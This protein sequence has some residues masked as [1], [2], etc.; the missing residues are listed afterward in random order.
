MNQ[1]RR[2]YKI[3]HYV[4]GKGKSGTEYKNYSLTVPIEIAESL[5]E[6]MQFIPRV[7]D[8]SDGLKG[9]LFEPVDIHQT[10]TP[11]WVQNSQAQNQA[12]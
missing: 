6:N 1:P 3:R 8:E 2:G 9:L 10:K 4:S 11:T 5:P 7:L 12:A